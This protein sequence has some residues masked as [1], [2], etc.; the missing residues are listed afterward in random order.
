V[1]QITRFLAVAIA[2][3][4]FAANA[5]AQASGIAI[6]APKDP[7]PAIESGDVATIAFTV[8]NETRD[9]MVAEPKIDVPAGWQIVMSPAATVVAPAGFELWLV[10]VKAPAAATAG[11]YTIRVGANGSLAAAGVTSAKSAVS[12]S[13][14]VQIAERHGV[15]LFALGAP[16]Y[17][18]AGDVYT[19]SFIIR[20][21]GNVPSRFTVVAKSSHGNDPVLEQ[22][23]IA[24]AA[25]AID[26]VTASVKIPKTVTSAVQE[27]LDVAAADATVDTVRAEASM[28]TTVVPTASLGPTLWTIPGEFALRTSSANAGVSA[29]TAAGSGKL[30]PTSDVKVDFSVRG[31]TGGSSMFGEQEEYRLSLKNDRAA[32]RLGD[33]SF[34]FSHLVSGGGRSTGAEVTGKF[35]NYV[36]GA[37]VHRNRIRP[38]AATEASAMIGTDTRRLV[39]GS[40]VGLTRANANLLSSAARASIGDAF[41]EVEMAASDSL[42]RSGNAGSVRV[43]GDSRYFTYDASA[44]RASDA[45]AS[46]RQGSTDAHLSVSGHQM[47]GVYLTGSTNVQ[48]ANPAARADAI[49][50]RL[51][52]SSLAAN[53][54]NGMS[55]EL[56][57]FDRADR[58]TAV[59]TRGTQHTSRFRSRF[60][61]GAFDVAFNMQG[62]LVSQNDS[63]RG[64]LT[65][66]TTTTYSFGD[67]QFVSLFADV[68]DGRGLGEGG[69]MTTTTGLNTEL[70]AADTRLRFVSSLSA[71]GDA[72][73]TWSSHTDISVEREVRRSTIALRSR[74]SAGSRMPMNHAV[75]LEVK[76]GLRVPTAPIKA[77]GRARAYVVDAESGLGVAGALIRLGG[78]AAVT[79]AN[80][81]AT[82]RNLTPGEHRAVVDGSAVAGRVITNN[83]TVRISATSRAPAE[84]RVNLARGVRLA[85]RLRRFEKSSSAIANGGDTLTEVGAMGQVVVALVSN[86]DTVWQTSDDRGRVDF[87]GLAPGQ[88]TIALPRFEAPEFMALSQKEFTVDVTGGE[89]RQVDFKL[90]PQVRA[91]EF[92][93]ETVII[94]A[95][96]KAPQKPATTGPTTVTG[97]PDPAPITAR[98]NT[99]Q[100]RTQN[101]SAPRQQQPERNQ[102]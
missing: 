64:A 62:A 18:M 88:Y 30:T 73:H 44:N 11:N 66:G 42:G 98:P 23:T 31:P 34:G 94:A 6:Q 35:G 15:S 54:T 16:A 43:N 37:Y 72:S 29:F 57:R 58:G 40:L 95:P 77:I 17:V 13:V 68:S 38:D 60:D 93:G 5:R 67:N 48:I 102:P 2:A 70:T 78:Q 80:G 63:A 10:S 22:T 71:V 52:T 101:P 55:L 14:R 45:F 59:A 79:D 1:K 20:N 65:I 96:A 74:I 76:T 51:N 3:S 49:G 97:K 39:S 53:F 81:V 91:V 50:Q 12:D 36:A 33:Q 32:I 100:P 85:V 86:R 19:G 82:F 90:V 26:T 25:G 4:A 21:E 46:V 24:L 75:F 56:E 8:R 87:N 28:Q 89:Q 99:A 69:M 92:V 84:F 7:R 61:L 83:S 9:T 41:V 27:L 47:G